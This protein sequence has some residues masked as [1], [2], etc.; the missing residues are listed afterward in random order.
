MC[1]WSMA[2]AELCRFTTGPT[3]NYEGKPLVCVSADGVLSISTEVTPDPRWSSGTGFGALS[4][5][6]CDL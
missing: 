1:A 5:D 2:V 6:C 3:V 4:H